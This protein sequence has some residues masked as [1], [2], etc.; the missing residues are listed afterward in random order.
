MLS[1]GTRQ[2]TRLTKNPQ[3][4]HFIRI[5]FKGGKAWPLPKDAGA[6]DKPL[7]PHPG[8]N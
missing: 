7:G 3:K 6:N 5:R 4:P 1:G 2:A 8:R